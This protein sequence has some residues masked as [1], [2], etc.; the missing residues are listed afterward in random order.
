MQLLS[1]PQ[2]FDICLKANNVETF[3][4]YPVVQI[5]EDDKQKFLPEGVGKEIKDGKE[6]LHRIIQI[7]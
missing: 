4:I 1:P 3:N 7:K 5:F 6:C 2:V